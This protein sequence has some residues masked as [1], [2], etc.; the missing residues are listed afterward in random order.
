[1]SPGSGFFWQD[2]ARCLHG[3]DIGE[4]AVLHSICFVLHG[5]TVAL[6]L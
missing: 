1:M 2:I 3:L 5:L 4:A 6:E